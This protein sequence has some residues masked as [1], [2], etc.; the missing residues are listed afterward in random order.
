LVNIIRVIRVHYIR[1]I[2]V[3][4]IRVIRV[5]IIRVIR[6]YKSS[7]HSMPV[8][9]SGISFELY[10]SPK[11]DESGRNILCAKVVSN[12]TYTQRQLE[13]YMQKFWTIHPSDARR[14][15][16][17]F[18]DAVTSLLADGYRVDT[19]IGSFYMKLKLD[20]PY[21][22]ADKVTA[23]QVGFD[24]VGILPD[25]E[26][27]KRVSDSIHGFQRKRRHRSPNLGSAAELQ[28]KVRKLARDNGGFFDIR[29]F[30]MAFGV[31]DYMARKQLK[32]LSEGPSPFLCCKRMGSSLTYSLK[33]ETPKENP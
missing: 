18:V 8:N 12:G 3:H 32:M 13:E 15:M 24:G 26:F 27:V 31:S 10:D 16:T 19:A 5:N 23:N 22:A 14:F 2:R 28:R 11:K 30:R 6:V 9:K 29:D 33:V 20:A 21:T 1:V 17:A 4:N 25:K 7:N